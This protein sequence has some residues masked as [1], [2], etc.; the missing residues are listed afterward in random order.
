MT[1]YRI[2]APKRGSRPPS[3]AQRPEAGSVNLST[4]KRSLKAAVRAVVELEAKGQTAYIVE[5][6]GFIVAFIGEILWRW[7]PRRG[8]HE[9]DATCVGW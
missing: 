7:E 9:N 2:R 4:P 8:E 5:P 6:G 3:A 1:K